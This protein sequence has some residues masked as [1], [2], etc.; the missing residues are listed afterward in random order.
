[1]YVYVDPCRRRVFDLVLA[2]GRIL[3]LLLFCVLFLILVPW[4]CSWSYPSSCLLMALFS[5]VVRGCVLS[6]VLDLFLGLAL[7]LGFVVALV[8][9]RLLDACFVQHA[10]QIFVIIY[11]SSVPRFDHNCGLVRS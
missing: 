1:M 4:Y 3:V 5:V 8:R 9:V 7:V 2:V 11:F 10:L 6:L